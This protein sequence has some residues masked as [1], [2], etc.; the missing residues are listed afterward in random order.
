MIIYAYGLEHIQR[1]LRDNICAAENILPGFY[2]YP[3]FIIWSFVRLMHW[4]LIL[5]CTFA[6]QFSIINSKS[7][8][9]F[10]LVDEFGMYQYLSHTKH[11]LVMLSQLFVFKLFIVHWT[12]EGVKKRVFIRPHTFFGDR[13]M[14]WYRRL[15]RRPK[16][17]LVSGR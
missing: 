9:I 3:S 17:H 16:T 11:K 2:F 7:N 10:Q 15:R 1:M 13:I 14:A 6:E 4:I 5:S 12:V 8:E